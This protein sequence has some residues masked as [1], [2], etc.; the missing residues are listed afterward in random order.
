MSA[1]KKAQTRTNLGQLMVRAFYWIDEGLQSNLQVIGGPEIT[2][3]QSMIIMMIGEG[4]RRP[5]AIAERLGISRQAVHQSLRE[6][7]DAGVVELVAD[8]SDGRAKLARLSKTGAPIHRKARR[9]LDKLEAELGHRIGKR[10]VASLRE[11]LE[12][13][14]GE[15]LMFD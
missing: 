12:Q 2:H 4:F 1:K 8:P 7:I 3:S 11:V 5:S 9:I 13:D 10:R 15:P 14:W 6:L